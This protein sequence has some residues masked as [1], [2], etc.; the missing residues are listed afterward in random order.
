[1][2]ITNNNIEMLLILAFV[3]LLLIIYN[4]NSCDLYN[5]TEQFETSF[6]P[7]NPNTNYFV[8]NQVVYNGYIYIVRDQAYPSGTPLGVT[9]D[10]NSNIWTLQNAVQVTT[11]PTIMTPI[12]MTPTM[13]PVTISPMTMAPQTI[14]PMAM[15][16]TMSPQTMS[17]MSMTQTMSP[18]TMSPITMTPTSTIQSVTSTMLWTSNSDLLMNSRYGTMINDGISIYKCID[19][20]VT[21]NNKCTSIENIPKSSPAVWQYI[22]QL[23]IQ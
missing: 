4:C 19:T 3:L 12:T 14:S 11:A 18:V 17:P 1:M 7:W 21:L 20:D 2:N 6:P 13:T 9:P 5:S 10:S 8:G 22:E 23:P 15:T 16:Q